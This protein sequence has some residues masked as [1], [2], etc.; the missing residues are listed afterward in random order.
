ML[1]SYGTYP[2]RLHITI[3]RFIDGIELLKFIDDQIEWFVGSQ[4]HQ[5]LKQ[6]PKRTNLFRNIGIE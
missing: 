4:L 3:H 5:E 2:T 1:D 6:R